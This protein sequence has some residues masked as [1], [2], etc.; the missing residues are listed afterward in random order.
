MI[1]NVDKIYS[2]DVTVRNLLDG[3]RV[4]LPPFPDINNKTVRGITISQYFT[5]PGQVGQGF[6]TL[7]DSKKN[8]LLYTYSLQDLSDSSS[9]I[10]GTV[11]KA[12]FIRQ[13]NLFDIETRSSYFNFNQLGGAPSGLMFR[14][15]FYV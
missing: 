11:P 5:E 3:N 2:L 10:V 7:L 8:V 6:L 14:I 15:S 12:F 9:Q 13:F 1:P 4:F